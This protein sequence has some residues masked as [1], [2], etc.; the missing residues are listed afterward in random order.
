MEWLIFILGIGTSLLM[1]GFVAGG[2]SFTSAYNT[3]WEDGVE[4]VINCLPESCVRALAEEAIQ[5]PRMQMQMMVDMERG[6][7]SEKS[8]TD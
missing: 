4:D 8:Q 1:I 3:G 2:A 6:E 5:D 7:A